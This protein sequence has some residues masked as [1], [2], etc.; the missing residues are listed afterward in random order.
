M[1]RRG[2]LAW[3]RFWA[4]AGEPVEG[5]SQGYLLGPA[6]EFGWNRHVVTL[7]TLEAVRCLVL[8][9]DPGMGKSTELDR[10]V[11]RLRVAGSAVVKIDLALKTDETQL[12]RDVFEAAEISVWQEGGGELTLLL[13]ALDESLINV[14]TFAPNLLARLAAL[15][16]ERLRLRIACRTADWPI[17]LDRGLVQAFATEHVRRFE[18]LALRR[19]DVELAARE[20]G[21]DIAVFFHALDT[22]DVHSLAT[23]PLTLEM[24]VKA[25]GPQG[26][27]LPTSRVA[28]FSRAVR[29][30]ATEHDE[31]YARDAF[32]FDPSHRLAAAM[33]IAAMS[34]LCAR[35]RIVLR[36]DDEP[37]KE[38]LDLEVL[39]GR[40]EQVGAETV[41]ITPSLLR[42][43][44]RTALFTGAAVGTMT[45]SHRAIAEYL[46]ARWLIANDIIGDRL[47]PLLLHPETARS[48]VP[49]LRG[50]A[51]WVASMDRTTLDCLAE[52]DPLLLLEADAPALDEAARARTTSGVLERMDT[53]EAHDLEVDLRPHYPKLQHPGL[54]EQLRAYIGDESRNPVVRRVAID[55]AEACSLHAIEDVLLDVVLNST[56]H[57]G[58]RQ[59]AASAI[60]KMGTPA[61]RRRLSAFLVRRDD[62]PEDSLLAYALDALWPDHMP[63]SEMFERLRVRQN[64]HH[65]GVYAMFLAR[66]VG[67][68]S[69]AEM[70]IAAAWASGNARDFPDERVISEIVARARTL[71]AIPSIRTSYAQLVV[72]ALEEHS[73]EESQSFRLLSADERRAVLPLVLERASEDWRLIG[74]TR[75]FGPGDLAWLP[76]LLDT[77]LPER[78]RA[79]LV[80]LLADVLGLR[81]KADDADAII[82][83]ARRHSDLEAAAVHLL[84]AVDIHGDVADYQRRMW[85]QI[86]EMSAPETEPPL[87]PSPRQRVQRGLDESEGGDA[88]VW[89]QLARE[90]TLRA[91]SRAYGDEMRVDTSTSPGWL[92]ADEPTRMRIV[93]AAQR[94]LEHT[95]AGVDRWMGRDILHLP[96]IGG[97]RA[98]RLLLDVAPERLAALSTEAWRAWAPAVIGLRNVVSGRDE[99]APELTQ[100]AYAKAPVETIATI[101]DVI[102]VENR[103]HGQIFID[104]VFEILPYERLDLAL[105]DCLRGDRFRPRTVGAIL[106]HLLRRGAPAALAIARQTLGV[107]CLLAGV[108]VARIWRRSLTRR[109]ARCN[110][111]R[112]RVVEACLE[113][114]VAVCDALIDA[115]PEG[116]WSIV[117][118]WVG[119]DDRFARRAMMRVARRMDLRSSA[120]VTA[121][122]END[123]AELHLLLRRLFPEEDEPVGAGPHVITERESAGML[124]SRLLNDLVGRRTF[125]ARDALRRI[126]MASGERSVLVLAADAESRALADGWRPPGVTEVLALA[127]RREARIVDSEAHLLDVVVD[128]LDR[129]CAK[130]QGELPR[131][132]FLWDRQADGS[133]RPKSEEALSDF[134]AG[135][136]GDEVVGRGVVVNREVQIR[137]RRGTRP[138]ERTDIH[139][140]AVVPETQLRLRVIIEVKGNWHPELEV[141]LDEQ[142]SDRYLEENSCRHGIYLVGWFGSE[143]WTRHDNRRHDA[144]ARDERAAV[145][146]LRAR[147]VARSV[148]GRRIRVVVMNLRM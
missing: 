142:L 148:A 12:L 41:E 19:A 136:L 104:T 28:L 67:R 1:A 106:T 33:R 31:L 90:L 43:T 96:A 127:T 100:R 105:V 119:S 75:L 14:R 88:T 139:V 87:D 116:A 62:D 124:R 126:A 6:P 59:Q 110:R 57:Y 45:S 13:D 138:G 145:D 143:R 77:Q 56:S 46:S 9:G 70:V 69:D 109:R 84:V 38:E 66:L 80:H 63:T 140:D 32:R 20:A 44:V 49:Q 133:L 147:A 95:D 135:E 81:L 115:H 3:R 40:V 65:Y 132:Q 125:A 24:L 36:T 11:E 73:S 58:T 107:N 34:V 82:T 26:G 61:G 50:V 10:E 137:P 93:D 92:D 23:R 97:Y 72:H 111:T 8:L 112:T 103:A 102:D 35:P 114:A 47:S 99:R 39:P 54:E 60:A 123:V 18:L 22:T 51:S 37:S 42:E 118:R 48:V 86:T 29:R 71:L 53:L 120:W 130:L 25:A 76:S 68:L 4:P 78:T 144:E 52:V 79:R 83:A 94:Y 113:R 17:V 117:W 131:V 122:S 5:D 85:A 74:V 101:L 91:S 2:G 55:I 98:I 89:W 146:A 7:D 15:P 64:P 27:Q 129:I 141:S 134:I 128:A 108:S 121:M 30:L 21:L 16:L